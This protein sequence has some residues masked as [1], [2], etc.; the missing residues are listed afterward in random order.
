MD[1]IERNKS[2]AEL[3]PFYVNGTLSAAE[4]AEVE[5]LLAV[6]D[7]LRGQLALLKQ[8]RAVMKD[9]E[10]PYSPGELGLARLMGATR[11]A[12][13]R[14]VPIA[15]AASV[16]GLA[17]AAVLYQSLAERTPVYEQAGA[18]AAERMILVAFRPAAAQ[19]DISEFLLTN[20]VTIVDG[21]S[22]IGLYSVLVAEGQSKD[23]ILARIRAASSLVE[24]A[25]F[26]E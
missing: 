17:L 19:G 8:V 3:L 14:W 16:T 23:D 11:P 12:A 15:V 26:A 25:E 21:P 4:R 6:D 9:Q 22:A 13:N 20:D 5:A 1:R 2:G 24:S 10:T 7:D 18:V